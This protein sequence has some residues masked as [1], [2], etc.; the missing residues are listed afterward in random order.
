MEK[1]AQKFQILPSEVLVDLDRVLAAG[2]A[3]MARKSPLTP[4]QYLDFLRQYFPNAPRTRRLS[5]I[6]NFD[7]E[8]MCVLV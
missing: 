6:Q 2:D 4:D 7:P 3:Y 1:L 8:L 5:E